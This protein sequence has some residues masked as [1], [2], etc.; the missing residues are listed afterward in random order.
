M[1][2]MDYKNDIKGGATEW[3]DNIKTTDI[4]FMRNESFALNSL[5]LR[6]CKAKKQKYNQ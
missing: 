4:Y 3:D 1:S 2:D 6:I 5:H